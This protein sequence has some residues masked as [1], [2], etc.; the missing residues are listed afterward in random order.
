VHL[1]GLP[2]SRPRSLVGGL[3]T[4]IALLAVVACSQ[5][6]FRCPEKGGPAWTRVV[7]EHF[8]LH[9]DLDLNSAKE[10]SSDLEAM[11]ATLSDLAFPSHDRPKMAV[12]VVMFKND[13]EFETIVDNKVSDGAFVTG[14]LHDFERGSIAILKA[15][16]RNTRNVFQHELTHFM[17][18][19]Y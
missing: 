11:F 1:R 6:P 8:V 14:G 2:I 10:A 15:D 16:L 13:E 7:S 3:A 5:K 12:E 4:L 9:T 17:V 18:S 19:Y